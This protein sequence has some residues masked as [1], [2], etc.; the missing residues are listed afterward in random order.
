MENAEIIELFEHYLKD[1][2][3]ASANTLSSYMRDIRQMAAYLESHTDAEIDTADAD[4]LGG[5]IAWLDVSAA[6]LTGDEAAE[7][8]EKEQAVLVDPGSEYGAGGERFIRLNLATQAGNMDEF[9]AR[10]SEIIRS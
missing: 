5:Y 9:A 6:G 7:R 10:L 4:D 8:L 3:G 2:K 1:E